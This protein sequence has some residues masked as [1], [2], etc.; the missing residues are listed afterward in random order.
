M[1]TRAI[2]TSRYEPHDLA[3]L[4]PFN[5]RVGQWLPSLVK[6]APE[7]DRNMA[8]FRRLRTPLVEELLEGEVAPQSGPRSAGDALRQQREALGLDLDDIA[9]ALRIKPDYLA[10]LEAGR[11]D[12]LPG[13]TYAIGFVRTYSD[14]LGLDGSEILRRFKAES[15]GLEAKTDLAFPMPLGERSIPGKSMLLLALILMLCGYGTWYY[16]STSERSR[17]ERVAEVPIALLPSPSA[18]GV[19]T[20]SAR[21][22]TAEIQPA[23][24]AGAGL[25]GPA[26]TGSDPGAIGEAVVA[27]PPTPSGKVPDLWATMSVPPPAPPPVLVGLAPAPQSEAPRAYGPADGPTRIVIRATSESWIKIRDGNQTVLLEGFLKTGETYRVPDRPGVSMRTGNAGGL[28][29]TVDGKPVPPI[30]GMGAV[31]NVR[32]EPQALMSGPAAGG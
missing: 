18:D 21:E 17:P 23:T 22:T 2:T 29:I 12:L 30:G 32:L 3:N 9:A 8:L 14:H 15:A 19:A 25:Q 7:R 27:P 28:D 10:A 31:R 1:P 5:A 13:P 11:P 20:P 24:R 4:N 16:L 26:P 6:M